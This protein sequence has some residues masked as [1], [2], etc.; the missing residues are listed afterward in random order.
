MRAEAASFG[1]SGAGQ[2]VLWA[3]CKAAT[4]A[5]PNARAPERI[6]L[7]TLVEERLASPMRA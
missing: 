2:S 3:V 6:V 7:Y 1:N 5:V 4:S